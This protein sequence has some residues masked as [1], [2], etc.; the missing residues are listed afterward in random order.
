MGFPKGQNPNHP[1]PGSSIKV[2]P[3]RKKS[4]IERIKKILADN[5]RDLCLFTLGINTA[6]R[7]NELLSIR[8]EQVK[9]LEVGDHIDLKQSKTKQSCTQ[10]S[11]SL[12]RAIVKF[13]FSSTGTD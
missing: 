12:I 2:E 1:K 3:I 7:A 5:P 13:W 8:V 4:A 10:S 6:Y 9:D 11:R